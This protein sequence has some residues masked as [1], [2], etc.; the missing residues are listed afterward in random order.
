M[1]L[2]ELKLMHKE[3]EYIKAAVEFVIKSGDWDIFPYDQ[4]R[5]VTLLS[6]CNQL[7]IEFPEK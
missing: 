2:I 5:M 1:S 3:L 7:K 6:L 4:F